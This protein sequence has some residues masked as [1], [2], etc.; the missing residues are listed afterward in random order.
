MHVVRG[1]AHIVS[2]LGRPLRRPAVA[3][4]NFDG[5]HRGH[6]ALLAR[7]CELAGPGGEAVALTFDPHPARFFAGP[8]AP[9]LL[10]PLARR[11]ERLAEEGMDVT[12]VE[13]FDEHLA[14]LEAEAFV[15]EVLARDLGAAHLVVG[16]DFSFGRGRRGDAELLQA[17]GAALGMTVSVVS[18]V[19]VH[20]ITCS[21]TQVRQFVK[22][23]HVT[24]ATALLGRP[25]TIDGKV[26]HGAARGRTI[27]FPTAN[28]ALEGELAPGPG[29][30]AGR[31]TCLDLPHR[32]T[33]GAAIS[34]GRNPTFVHDAD[35]PLQIEAYLLD[36]SGDLY[37]QQ[38]RLAFVDRLRDELPFDGVPALVKQIERDVA[39]TRAVLENEP[40]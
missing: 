16:Y 26:V 22:Q 1:R 24:G 31:A 10:M 28:L 14:N 19:K 38:L 13:T 9:P 15:S 12:L 35:A 4:G 27:G 8:Q 33:Y 23:G 34:I 3:I 32:P 18:K 25:F 20:G 36:F 17:R 30:Y 37:L 6:Q 2:T 29:I 21:S 7:A 11:L 5:V 40:T 39:Q